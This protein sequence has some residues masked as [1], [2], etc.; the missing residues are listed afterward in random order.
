VERIFHQEAM[1]FLPSQN[2]T[3]ILLGKKTGKGEQHEEGENRFLLE[4]IDFNSYPIHERGSPITPWL[5]CQW[6]SSLL[7]LMHV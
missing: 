4:G 3:H 1:H 6:E 2:R 5:R 7:S